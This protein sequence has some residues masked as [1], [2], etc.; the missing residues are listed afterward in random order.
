MESSWESLVQSKRNFLT[1]GGFV[2]HRN[3]RELTAGPLPAQEEA[4]LL[5]NM[6]ELSDREQLYEQYSAIINHEKNF[7]QKLVKVFGESF[8]HK[9]YTSRYLAP[10][11]ILNSQRIYLNLDKLLANY[12]NVSI[13]NGKVRWVKPWAPGITKILCGVTHGKLSHLLC[14]AVVHAAA[15]VDLFDP[16]G[17]I[18]LYEG[19]YAEITKAISAGTGLPCSAPASTRPNLNKIVHGRGQCSTWSVL[20]LDL[21]ETLRL[22]TFDELLHKIRTEVP[23]NVFYTI[24]ENYAAWLHKQIV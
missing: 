16:N 3:Y 2:F 7:R 14:A 5:A 20:M 15:Y 6:P 11:A 4:Q 24:T 19:M 17:S 23:K 13:V 1:Y 21:L 8:S 10:C 22:D 18:E 12:S 9:A